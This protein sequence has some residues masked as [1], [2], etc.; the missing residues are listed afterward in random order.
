M[1]KLKNVS[2]FYYNK[3]VIASGFNKVNVEFKL[4]EFVA[5]VGESGSG[6]STLLNVISGLDSYEEGEMYINGE[7]TSHYRE[8]DFEEY[9]KKYVS[10]IFQN[11]NLVNSY[12]VYQNIELVL[13]LNGHKR[14]EVKEKVLELIDKVGLT[15][16][17]RTKVSKLSG[18]QKQRVAIARALA[19]ETPIIV[20]DEPTA[21]LDSRSAKSIIKLLKDISQDKLVIVVTHN[22]SEIEEVATRVVKMHD[23]KIISDKEIRKTDT[24]DQLVST[25]NKSIGIFNMIRLGIRNTFNI[26]P[27]FLLIFIVFLFIATSLLSVYASLKKNEYEESKVGFNYFFNDTTD[28]RIIIKKKDG[29]SITEDDFNKIKNLKNVASIVK[30]DIVLD[31]SLWFES[32]DDNPFSFSGNLKDISDFNQSLDHGTMPTKENEVILLVDSYDY[33]FGEKVDDA[34]NKTYYY[35]GDKGS[36]S[37]KVTGVKYRDETE[38]NIFSTIFR[39]PIIYANQKLID[40]YMGLI[41]RNHSKVTVTVNGKIHESNAAMGDTFDIRTSDRVP[42][43]QAYV[44]ENMNYNCKDFQCKN[45]TIIIDVK[46]IYYSD[47]IEL[48][49]TNIYN[50]KNVK[51]LL[52]INKDDN[53]FGSIYMNRTDYDN[54]FN[55][56]SYQASVMANHVDNVDDLCNKLEDLGYKTLQI[57][58][59][60][61]NDAAEVLKVLKIMKLV[62]IISLVI[63]LFFISYFVIKLILKSRNVYYSTLRILGANFRHIKRILDVEL[64]TNATFAY[65][66]YI[67]AI[68]LV[69][70]NVIYVKSIVN[71]VDYL[72]LRDYVLMYVILIVMSYLISTR[73][74]RKIFKTSAMKSYREEV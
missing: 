53:T 13:L 41:N 16:Y 10:N 68:I 32:N 57:R 27:K 7:E 15:K 14:K 59:T 42:R 70:Y 74:A 1:L 55:K 66:A 64:F 67:V 28:T 25:E 73:Y 65:L 26:I 52:S 49:M 39:G 2:K 8:I 23:G 48:K 37:V 34:L 3:G 63:A 12:S 21:N 47:R 56:E 18:G 31:E 71:M 54:L 45:K 5:I 58:K 46:N 60:L 24:F 38:N 17:R 30:N 20:A 40:K 61:S 72:K 69:K 29:S 50:D 36:I 35:E 43:G 9:R 22:F 11:F 44:S 4:G 51:N 33:Y 19:K 6:K 62:V